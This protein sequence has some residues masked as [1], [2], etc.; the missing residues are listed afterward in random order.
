MDERDLELEQAAF[1]AFNIGNEEDMRGGS[2]SNQEKGREEAL[3]QSKWLVEC[4]E[5]EEE[6][7]KD[8]NNN[9]EQSQREEHSTSAPNPQHVQENQIEGQNDFNSPEPTQAAQET[10]HGQLSISEDAS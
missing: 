3:T 2:Q 1:E 8:G 6:R 7:D 5:A 4:Q 10:N 9:L